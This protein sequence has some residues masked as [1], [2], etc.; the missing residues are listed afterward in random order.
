MPE[1]KDSNKRVKIGLGIFAVLVLANILV[2]GGRMLRG[3]A[4][5]AGKPPVNAPAAAKTPG[6]SGGT[7][8]PVDSIAVASSSASPMETPEKF[9]E[10]R[11]EPLV[12]ALE[13]MKKRV[14]KIASPLAPPDSGL[15]LIVNDREFFMV[16]RG[17]V[18]T[19]IR[20]TVVK[21]ADRV[22]KPLKVLGEFMV[23]GKKRLLVQGDSGAYVVG[24]GLLHGAEGVS[25]L[26][27]Q[28]NSYLLKD[29]GGVK[30]S[31]DAAEVLPDKIREAV[32]VLRGLGQSGALKIIESKKDGSEKSGR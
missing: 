29:G 27:G 14:E 9:I 31:V 10:E 25:L 21:P 13:E 19:E 12:K 11:T 6:K 22:A 3:P 1:N 26:S 18:Q 24:D 23:N 16:S 2:H 30:T 4:S 17:A 15:S 8:R 20:P 32:K 28:G 7:S 5:P